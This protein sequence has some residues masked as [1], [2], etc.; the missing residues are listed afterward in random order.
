M[1]T[2]K[3]Q[4]QTTSGLADAGS[5]AH[6]RDQ[7]VFRRASKEVHTVEDRRESTFGKEG[8]EPVQATLAREGGRWQRHVVRGER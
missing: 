6:L 7:G 3:V 1:A 8:L 5:I 4:V 2:T